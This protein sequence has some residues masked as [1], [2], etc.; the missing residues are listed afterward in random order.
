MLVNMSW[1]DCECV[2]GVWG[3]GIFCHCSYVFKRCSSLLMVGVFGTRSHCPA[4]T[5]ESG[6]C[7]ECEMVWASRERAN[8]CLI[9]FL[10][11]NLR[12]AL[13]LF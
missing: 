11:R 12:H 9:L 6:R 13:Y 8:V 3:S 10:K 4:V 2:N 1:F 5:L 7:Y